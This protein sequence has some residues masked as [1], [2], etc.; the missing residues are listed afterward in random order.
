MS[1]L[2]QTNL[3][4]GLMMKL[5]DWLQWLHHPLAQVAVACSGI[6]MVIFVGVSRGPRIRLPHHTLNAEEGETLGE[7]KTTTS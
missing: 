4:A 7:D 1:C 5:A 6:G 3:F 2:F